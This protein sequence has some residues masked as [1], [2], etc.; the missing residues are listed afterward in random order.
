[1]GDLTRPTPRAE[2]LVPKTFGRIVLAVGAV[3]VVISF[4]NSFIWLPAKS[5]IGQRTE[6][7]GRQTELD[8]LRQA[9]DQIQKEIDWLNTPEGIE[10]AARSELGFVMAGEKRKVL[11]G[12]A[13]APVELPSGWP[14]DLV[15]QIVSVI[16]T[17]E[18]LAAAE[19]EGQ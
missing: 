19:Q 17:E 18:K 9:S 7:A 8:T 15:T 13:S 2:R 4:G 14:Y 5:W 1:L 6:A 3:L 10:A 11:V 16:E 12:T